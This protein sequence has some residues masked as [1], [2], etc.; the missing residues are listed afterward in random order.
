MVERLRSSCRLRLGSCRL[1]LRSC[2]LTFA[3]HPSFREVRL[4]NPVLIRERLQSL[5]NN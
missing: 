1:R 4:F 2:R 5:L 3:T